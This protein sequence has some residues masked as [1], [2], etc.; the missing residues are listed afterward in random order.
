MQNVQFLGHI[1]LK[2]SINLEPAKLE[3]ITKWPKPK[4]GNKLASL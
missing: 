3:K 2:K 4:T 1:M